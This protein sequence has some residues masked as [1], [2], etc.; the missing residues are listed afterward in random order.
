MSEDLVAATERAEEGRLMAKSTL[1]A[2]DR[3]QAGKLSDTKTDTDPRWAK[4][5]PGTIST[6]GHAIVSP[7]ERTSTQPAMVGVTGTVFRG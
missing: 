3:L 4:I 1:T 7:S 5:S 6:S 2:G